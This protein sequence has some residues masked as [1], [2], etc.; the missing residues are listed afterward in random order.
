MSDVAIPEVAELEAMLVYLDNLRDE[1]VTNMFGA[2]PY[3]MGEFPDLEKHQAGKVLSYWMQ[4]FAERH[5][6]S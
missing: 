4:T 1:G 6:V 3:L 5:P 2:R